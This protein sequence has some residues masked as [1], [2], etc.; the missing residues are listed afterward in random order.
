MRLPGTRYQEPGW[1]EVRKLLGQ[2]SLAAL[3][4]CGCTRLLD[5]AA[6]DE[7]LPDYVELTGERLRQARHTPR[8]RAAGNA[9]GDTVLEL[10]LALLYELQA[11]PGDW[12]AFVAALRAEAA[13]IDAFRVDAGGEA[14]LRKKVNDMYAVLRDKVDADNYQAACG[15]PCS[16]NRMYAYRMLDTAYGEIAR[17]FAGWEQHRAQVGAILGRE[18]HGS[19][20]EVR[21]LR[22]IADCRADWVLRWSESLEAFAGSVGPLH[23]RSKRFASLKGSPDKIAA[24]L[25]EI[26]DYEALSSNRDR[27]WLQDRDDAALWVEDYWRILQASEDAATPGPDLILE[28]RED[29][30]DAELAA[31]AEPEPGPLPAHDPQLEV[32][33]AAVSLPPGYLQAAGEGEDRSGWLARELAADGLV[34]RLA[35]YAKLL[36]PGDDSYPDAWRDPA[37]GELPTMQQLAGL[38][39]VS[40]PTLRKRRDAAI[41][42]LQ[43]ATMRRRG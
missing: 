14:L 26:G 9:Y 31:E 21:Q 2:C 7:T 11:R 41:A 22:S 27:D 37:T 35:V 34:L 40:L 42:R 8:A 16:P 17:L 23:T 43:A 24:M 13:R 28:A 5:P 1:E 18:L 20:I 6:A 38:A 30:L 19:P 39:Q 12:H 33:A 29:A 32:L 36:G 4:A 25:A 3:R 15:R 10:A